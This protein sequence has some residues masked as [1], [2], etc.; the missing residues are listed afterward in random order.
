[1]PILLDKYEYNQWKMNNKAISV[2]YL[3]GRWVGWGGLG[4]SLASALSISAIEETSKPNA[5]RI[6][7]LENCA[8]DVHRGVGFGTELLI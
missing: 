8:Q 4:P 7:E 3:Y 1:M 5:S 2:S 6:R